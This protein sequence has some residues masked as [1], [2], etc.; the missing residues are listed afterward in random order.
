MHSAFFVPSL[1]QRNWPCFGGMSIH[2]REEQFA[3]KTA[4]WADGLPAF[5]SVTVSVPDGLPFEKEQTGTSFQCS[6]VEAKNDAVAILGQPLRFAVALTTIGSVNF[7]K[8]RLLNHIPAGEQRVAAA[9][10]AKTRASAIYAINFASAD[11]ISASSR[12]FVEFLTDS[13][14]VLPPLSLLLRVL[15]SK[16]DKKQPKRVQKLVIFWKMSNLLKHVSK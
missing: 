13:C 8:S 10:V 2:S 3:P 15:C 4:V 1:H 16:N 12:L 11:L 5:H 7:S 14:C 9:V 6:F